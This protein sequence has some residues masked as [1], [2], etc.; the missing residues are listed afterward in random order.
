MCIYLPTE[1]ISKTSIF[2]FALLQNMV[3]PSKQHG[4]CLRTYCFTNLLIE[5]NRSLMVWWFTWVN[6]RMRRGI[7][8]WQFD[9]LWRSAFQR[10][11]YL[12]LKGLTCM[13][14]DSMDSEWTKTWHGFRK[15]TSSLQILN[16]NMS[17]FNATSANWLMLFWLQNV[18][19]TLVYHHDH[20]IMYTRMLHNYSNSIKQ[21]VRGDKQ[22]TDFI[23]QTLSAASDLL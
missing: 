11:K 15:Y 16:G 14:G 23:A 18:R 5:L 2:Q 22:Y 3:V 4:V 13:D 8:G 7:K 9:Q 19:G 17:R 10:R 6:Y 12:W 1:N 20:I 21:D